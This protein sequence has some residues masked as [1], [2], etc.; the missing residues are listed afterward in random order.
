[1]KRPCQIDGREALAAA[2][3]VACV[4]LLTAL[5][6]F[7]GGYFT[8]AKA[9]DIHPIPESAFPTEEE[10]EDIKRWIPASCCRTARCCF[11]ITMSALTPQPQD[12]WKINATGQVIKRTDWTQ[13][14]K[15]WRC[16]CDLQSNG[17]WLSHLTANTRC[18]FPVMQSAAR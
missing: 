1:M 14:G 6:Y 18:I 8:R 10:A 12:S 4:G 17:T 15:V 2:G 9:A 11:K 16:A 7:G 5:I 13:D 3:Y